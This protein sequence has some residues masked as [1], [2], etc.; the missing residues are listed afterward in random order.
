MKK[1][2]L[3][4]ALTGVMLGTTLFGAV[5]AMASDDGST[6]GTN[7][8]VDGGTDLS[9]WTFQ[10]LHYLTC[11]RYSLNLPL[12]TSGQAAYEQEAAQAL[13]GMDE[14]L[15]VLPVERR[16][17]EQ[18]AFSAGQIQRALEVCGKL[19]VQLLYRY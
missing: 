16:L 14:A 12:V 15:A 3:A 6:Q 17:E 19:H 2:L 7:T 18:T 11:R 5:P 9:F 13:C 1:K 10:E 4:V 8:F